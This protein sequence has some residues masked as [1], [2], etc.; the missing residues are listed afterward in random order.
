MLKPFVLILKGFG[1]MRKLIV[2]CL[3]GLCSVGAAIAADSS[4][5]G[6]YMCQ[7]AGMTTQS[8]NGDLNMQYYEAFPEIPAEG[9]RVVFKE[10]LIQT[11]NIL[12]NTVRNA[13]NFLS[14]DGKTIKEIK[15]SSNGLYS[16]KVAFND[17][18]WSIA[19][20][21]ANNGFYVGSGNM[22]DVYT[23]CKKVSN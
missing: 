23:D 4:G 10:N 19:G 11:Y 2:V 8:E 6:T 15:K 1:K 16:G 12:N 13:S 18:Y 20:T 7:K 3:T 21:L 22:V 14:I 17:H 5:Y 9:M